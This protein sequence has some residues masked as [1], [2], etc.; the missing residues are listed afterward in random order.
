MSASRVPSFDLSA[1]GLSGLCLIHCLALPLLS[2]VLPALSAWTEA[3][4]LHLAFAGAAVPI[5]ITALYKAHR[6]R[7][8]HEGVVFLATSGLAALVIGA[9]SPLEQQSGTALTVLGSTL[10]TVAHVWNWQ[11]GHGAAEELDES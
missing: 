11:R 4:W 5:S 7:P 1:I 3:E 2:A 9:V 10:L 6:G 8:L